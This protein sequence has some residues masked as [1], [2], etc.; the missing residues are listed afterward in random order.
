MMRSVLGAVAALGLLVGFVSGA[1]AST[2]VYCAEAAPEGFDPARYVTR[3]TLDASAQLFFDRLVEFAPGSTAIVPGL[4]ESW[5]I[6]PDG[7]TYT[8]HL[9]QN[10]HFH[11]T[12]TF[13]PKRDFSADDVVFSL[14]RQDDPKNPWFG[15]AGGSWPWF[16]SLGL[17]TLIRSIDKVDAAT[18]RITLTRADTGF[19]GDLAM[20]F[21]SIQSKEY[22]DTLLREKHLS[23]LDVA[24]VGTGPFVF[25]RTDDSHVYAVANDDYWGGAPKLDTIIFSITPNPADRLAKLKSGACQLAP[26]T[27]AATLAAVKAEAGLAVVTAPSADVVYLAFNASKPPFS[28]VRVRKALAQAI[29]RQAVADTI[30]GGL[31]EPATRLV[32]A[33][34]AGSDQTVPADTF[35]SEAAKQAFADAGAGSLT[36]KLL[37]TG[38]PRPYSPDLV[39]TANLIAA[40]L[41]RAGVTATVE[42]ANLSDYLRRSADKAR[43]EG[44]LI[45]WTS[46]NGDLDDFLS[47]LL[48]CD[49]VGKSNR[50]EWCDQA[51]NQNL[52]AARTAEAATAANL[53]NQAQLAVADQAPLVPLVHT[54]QAVASVKSVTG[55]VVDPLGRHNF[56]A[57]DLAQ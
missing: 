15:Y 35:N 50:A 36:V 42:T 55:Y 29:N 7:R 34:I 32:P 12:D 40:D 22:A 21:A 11:T 33:T 48:S 10:V 24:P 47:V 51:F 54:L 56:A 45:G 8:F 14:A 52:V 23:L 26:V 6:S 57:V 18:V 49:A 16:Q 5:E 25:N 53:L 37:V 20:D 46:A 1:S 41:A 27:D 28:D 19:L 31:A 43:D 39:G 9:R 3:P 38:T 2:L 13:A 44:A 30:Y 4:A 17:D